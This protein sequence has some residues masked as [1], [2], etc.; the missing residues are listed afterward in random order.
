MQEVTQKAPPEKLENL[1]ST[2][3]GLRSVEAV[4]LG[5]PDFPMDSLKLAAK[6]LVIY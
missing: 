2:A 1:L 4:A 3:F 6:I 5:L